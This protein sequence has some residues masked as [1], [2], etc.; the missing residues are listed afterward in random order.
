MIK[1][2]KHLRKEKGLYLITTELDAKA[3]GITTKSEKDIIDYLLENHLI[4]VSDNIENEFIV[5]HFKEFL[6]EV[7]FTHYVDLV[8]VLNYIY[9]IRETIRTAKA[10][11]SHSKF[12]F[13]TEFKNYISDKS[14]NE[15][16]E[17]EKE[18]ASFDVSF[19][20][21]ILKKN[22]LSPMEEIL[23]S[24]F[25]NLY[26]NNFNILAVKPKKVS[27]FL[28]NK[29]TSEGAEEFLYMNVSFCRPNKKK[30]N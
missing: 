26:D 3:A 16:D 25:N 11:P 5:E 6:I 19:K 17:E 15:E 9:D 14:E 13:V 28:K 30:E 20:T 21:D 10:H 12:L 23:F 27:L 18:V 22:D 7:V 29:E 4:K 24:A 2:L 1:I 8:S